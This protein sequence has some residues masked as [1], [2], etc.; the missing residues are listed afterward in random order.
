MGAHHASGPGRLRAG[1]RARRGGSLPPA[2]TTLAGLNEALDT[3]ER[4][5]RVWAPDAAGS[6]CFLVASYVALAAVCGRPWC[7]RRDDTPWRIAALNLL[8][9]VFFGI[10]AVTSF[11]L[12]D[13]GEVLNADATNATTFLGA[14]S[15]LAGG[16]LLMPRREPAARL[17]GAPG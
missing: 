10:S 12:P 3:Q 11:I 1:R 15:F 9:S 13:T 5:H 8:G 2:G 6:I 17:S 4:I 14:A 16:A 7:R